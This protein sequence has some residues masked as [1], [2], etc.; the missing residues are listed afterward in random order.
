MTDVM[1]NF[2]VM[3][4]VALFTAVDGDS[5]S[6]VA[7]GTVE[8]VAKVGF[9]AKTSCRE[10][11]GGDLSVPADPPI[12]A[13]QETRASVE[14]VAEGHGQVGS[15]CDLTGQMQ[16]APTRFPGKMEMQHGLPVARD[17]K[18]PSGT[19]PRSTHVHVDHVFDHA[20]QV[21]VQ[22]VLA[23]VGD[24]GTCYVCDVWACVFVRVHFTGEHG[25][26]GNREFRAVPVALS[27]GMQ[28][29]PQR[30]RFVLWRFHPRPWRV[31]P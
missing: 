18:P 30:R 6:H 2:H 21:Q 29:E 3:V 4:V 24:G 12:V 26:R 17:V 10:G 13:S 31:P 11:P 25:G 1:V 19:M 14:A 20:L 8:V 9:A 16:P 28:V 15:V 7:S 23:E 27:D 5:N 22:S